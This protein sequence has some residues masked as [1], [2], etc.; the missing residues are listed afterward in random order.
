MIGAQT[1]QRSATVSDEIIVRDADGRFKVLRHGILEDWTSGI[2]AAG[3][4]REPKRVRV[5]PLPT[6]PVV[7][8]PQPQPAPQAAPSVGAI[9]ESPLPTMKALKPAS[10]FYF[11][12]G[13]EEEIERFR[14]LSA[15]DCAARV[16]EFAVKKAHEIIAH[17]GITVGEELKPR[18]VRAVMSRLKDVRDLIETKEVL[19]RPRSLGGVN[20]DNS[21]ANELLR[22]VEEYRTQ[23]ERILAGLRGQEVVE[24]HK[25]RKSESV[26]A[27]GRSPVQ[28]REETMKVLPP[29]P[30]PLNIPIETPKPPRPFV[31]PSYHEEVESHKVIKSESVGANG[32][33]P[34]GEAGSPVQNAIPPAS[35]LPQIPDTRYQIPPV[36]LHTS[37]TDIRAHPHLVGP[38][39]ELKFMDLDDFRRL[40]VSAREAAGKIQEKIDLLT[41][42]SYLKRSEGIAAWKSS[43]AHMAYLELGIKSMEKGANVTKIIGEWQ[44]KGKPTLTADEFDAIADLNG[45]LAY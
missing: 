27:N 30:Q 23:F 29:A 17:A 3:A 44:H 19:L 10:R 15:R 5:L 34:A 4:S 1:N 32:R 12:V 26:G 7:P 31:H 43:P 41:D 24:S 45:K 6:E 28:I 14:D 20:L 36:P 9:H 37:V 18:L 16:N 13:D 8:Q 25:V 2:A 39:E 33:P 22:V 42:E 38:I 40:G 21:S 35:P 11:D